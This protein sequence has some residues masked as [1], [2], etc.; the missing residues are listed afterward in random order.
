MVLVVK[1]VLTNVQLVKPN[2]NNVL[3]VPLTELMLQTVTVK[4]D[5]SMMVSMPNVLNVL[6]DVTLVPNADLVPLVML[7]D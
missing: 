4:E 2:P 3:F 7:Q 5:T 1:F 6:I